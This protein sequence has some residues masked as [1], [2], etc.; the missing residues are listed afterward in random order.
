M[1]V[2]NWLLAVAAL[3]WLFCAPEAEARPVVQPAIYLVPHQDDELLTMGADMAAH[4][5]AGR[6][7]IVVLVTDGA[8]SSA[9]GKMCR[10]TGYCLTR[11]A[12][13]AARDREFAEAMRVMGVSSV[14]YERQPD[15]Q[16][17]DAAARAI[18]DR[19]VTAYPY[20]SIK[21][22]SWLDAHPDHAALGRALRASSAADAR[23]EQ[24]RPYWQTMPVRGHYVTGNDRMKRAAASYGL[25]RPWAGRYA[26]GARWSVPSAFRELQADPRSRVH[27]R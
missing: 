3:L 15:G 6:P 19:W 8:A 1:R 10:A 12:F 24:Y 16:L 2:A 27:T 23:F 17:S 14:H 4:V 25:W 5:A 7:V 20:A 9:R 11:E 21:T 13:S 26:I 18:V 22:M